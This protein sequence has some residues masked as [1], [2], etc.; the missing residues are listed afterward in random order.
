MKSKAARR[1]KILKVL[2]PYRPFLWLVLAISIPFLDSNPYHIDVMASAGIFV[3][4]ALGLNVIVGYA[5]I[6]NLGFAAFFAVGA[7]AYALLNLHWNIPFW[8]GLIF[9]AFTGSLFGVLLATP[10]IR[11]S[12]DYLAIVTLGAG[13]IVRI[14]LNNLDPLTGGPNGLLGIDH[15]TLPFMAYDFGVNSEPYYFLTLA[16]ITVV[17]FFMRRIENSR[18]GRAWGALREDELVAGFMGIDPIWAK[19]SAFALGG[20]VA[21]LAG[22]L[23][24]AKQGSVSPD[25]F[26]FILSVMV[27]AMVVLGG[28]GNI[29]GVILGAVLLSILPEFLRGF[30]I[31]RMLLFGL[32]MILVMLFRPQGLLGDLYQSGEFSTRGGKQ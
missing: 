4:L 5:G 16:L 27:L 12:G 1:R 6:L 28:L 29:Y 25:S 32:S 8:P 30:E 24:A 14:A 23:F 2:R 11:L 18:L 26:D 15:P 9:S 21:G 20:F 7:Y 19:L 3:L 22:S 31:Y 13:E 10:A 17:I